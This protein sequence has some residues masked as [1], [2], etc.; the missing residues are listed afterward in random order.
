MA[1]VGSQVVFWRLLAPSAHHAC[2]QDQRTLPLSD[3]QAIID[4]LCQSAIADF[5]AT[6]QRLERLRRD[7]P[8]PQ[9]DD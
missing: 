4:T 8:E 1:P 3:F 7:G 9:N 6:R 2:M 5:S